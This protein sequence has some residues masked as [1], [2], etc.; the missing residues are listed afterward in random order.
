[1]VGAATEVVFAPV[2]FLVSVCWKYL[3]YTRWWATGK[4]FSSD[5]SFMSFVCA[6]IALTG[7][8]W[9]LRLLIFSLSNFCF[10]LGFLIISRLNFQQCAAECGAFPYFGL[11]YGGT[12]FCGDYGSEIDTRSDA[13]IGICTRPCTDDATVDC[14]G[15]RALR[16]FTQG[17]VVVK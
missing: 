10:V 1:M 4:H 7:C 16:V 17:K 2:A 11:K 13:S 15:R 3:C 14:G 12:C 5:D 8:C 6:I 9:C